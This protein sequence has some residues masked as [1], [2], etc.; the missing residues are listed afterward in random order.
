M[1]APLLTEYDTTISELNQQ[2]S[3]YQ[4]RTRAWSSVVCNSRYMKWWWISDSWHFSS[5]SS[6]LTVW[7][8]VSDGQSAASHSGK[9]QVRVCVCVCVGGGG[10]GVS[11][12]SLHREYSY[13]WHTSIPRLHS[14]LRKSLETQ[15]QATAAEGSSSAEARA[16]VQALHHQL[17]VLTK[18]S[19]T[20]T[21]DY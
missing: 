5:S 12:H 1:L 9:Y 14:E 11:V 4:V 20:L 19:W 7:T 18:V 2:I 6:G 15:F 10:G 13:M 16:A 21:L 3:T 17:E 8:G